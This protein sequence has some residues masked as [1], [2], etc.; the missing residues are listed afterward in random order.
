MKKW[1]VC[2]EWAPNIEKVNAPL[3][4][5]YARNPS[6]ANMYRGVPFR[7][8]PWCGEYLLIEGLAGEPP[9]TVTDDQTTEGQI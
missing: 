8:C 9:E 4:L 1:C 2:A 5:A 3:M 7:Y 6:A